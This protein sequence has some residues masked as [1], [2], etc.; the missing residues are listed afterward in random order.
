MYDVLV[1]HGS[2]G[3]PFGNWAPYLFRESERAAKRCLVPHFPGPEEQSLER[4]ASVLDGYGSAIGEST[5]VAAHSIGCAFIASWCVTKKRR[6]HHLHLVAPFY[7]LLGSPDFDNIN[8]TFFGAESM[9]A[10]LSKYATS[11]TCY[12]STNDPYV[13]QQLGTSFCEK[14]GGRLQIIENA[15]HFN[16]AAGYIEF[17]T[18]SNAILNVTA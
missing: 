18:L 7:A 17:P 2:F 9:L 13:P 15:G 16:K 1:V 8:R 4:W 12:V 3:D 5:S 10:D 11:I 6:L 14:V